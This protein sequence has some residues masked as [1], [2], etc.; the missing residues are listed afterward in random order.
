MRTRR[1]KI[2]DSIITAILLVLSALL[3]LA[4]A[5]FIGFVIYVKI[6]YWGTPIG[7]IPYWAWWLMN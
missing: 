2:K 5:F 1:R 4:F 7:E 3:F 6:K